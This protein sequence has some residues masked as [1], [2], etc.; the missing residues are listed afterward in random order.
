MA[1]KAEKKENV[2]IKTGLKHKWSLLLT[3]LL[4][5]AGT[6]GT[7]AIY[8]FIYKVIEEIADK[9]AVIDDIDKSVLASMCIGMLICAAAAVLCTVIGSVL[10]H[11]ASYSVGYELRKGIMEKLSKVELGFF[12][13]NRSGD[14]KK[15]VAEDCSSIEKF[16]AEHIG[17]LVTGILT[18]IC[19]IIL[20]FNIDVKMTFAALL[21]IPFALIGMIFIMFNKKYMKANKAYSESMGSITSDAVEYFKALPVVRI[22]NSRGKSEDA[23]R[24]DIDDIHKYTYE[25]GKHSMFGYTFFTTFITASLL[26]ILLMSVYEY[27]SGGDLW[28]I[29]SKVLFFYIVGANLAGPMMNLTIFKLS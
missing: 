22:F 16:F 17:D 7:I 14:I 6:A 11:S 12:S 10:A 9:H 1:E 24:K 28:A 18:P 5:V 13:K 23:L 4:D 27:C 3:V 15:A 19:L 8:Y 26:G 29:I 20:M 25:Q 2:V 21:S